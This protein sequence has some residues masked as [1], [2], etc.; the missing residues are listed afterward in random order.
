MALT[1]KEA[2]QILESEDV[3]WCNPLMMW[4]GEDWF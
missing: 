4:S 1:R 3:R 2:T